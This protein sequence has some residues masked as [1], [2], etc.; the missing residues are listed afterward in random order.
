MTYNEFSALYGN[1]SNLQWENSPNIQLGELQGYSVPFTPSPE[2]YDI[3]LSQEEVNRN[4]LQY[5][6]DLAAANQPQI[7]N[8]PQLSEVSKVDDY[9]ASLFTTTA[10]QTNPLG[11]LIS[12]A[13]QALGT[14]LF[15]SI[16]G[17]T[18]PAGQSP[19]STVYQGAPM[20]MD[21]YARSL[22][23]CGPRKVCKIS[24][25]KNPKNPHYGK[26]VCPRMNPLNPKAL[27]RATRRLA[28]FQSFATKT[29]KV[30]RHMFVKAG[31]H[32]T[33]RVGGKCGTCRKTRCSCG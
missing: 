27:A 32:P 26:P 20:V 15:N 8:L 33:R 17:P 24:R 29:E 12:G 13:E 9:T 10:Q 14:A 23:N 19:A 21:V 16:M 18:S 22:A 28:G 2:A 25:A 6:Q 1:P 7:P 30:I 11:N 3:Q 5:Q 31:V 4:F